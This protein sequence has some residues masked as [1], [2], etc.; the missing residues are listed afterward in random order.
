MAVH[1]DP[2]RSVAV[3]VTPAALV[4]EPRALA[5][6]DHE[7]VVALP[8]RLLGEGVPEP[9][10]IE[11]ATDERTRVTGRFCQFATP[12]WRISPCVQAFAEQRRA[13]TCRALSRFRASTTHHPRGYHCEEDRPSA[14]RERA[15]RQ[16]DG[17]DRRS[18]A[19]RGSA[20]V[21]ARH[22]DRRPHPAGGR[23]P[24]RHA[25]AP[26]S[27]IRRAWRSSSPRRSPRSSGSSKVVVQ[28][29]VFPNLRAGPQALRPLLRRGDDHAGALQERRLLHP[30]HQCRSGRDDPQ[31]PDPGA[32]VA[33]R[34]Q[35]ADALRAG[36]HDGR[37]VHQGPHQAR[38]GALP[39]HDSDHVPA[40]QSKQCDVSVY[41]VPILGA[42]SGHPTRYGDIVGRIVTHEQYGIVFQKGSKLRAVVNPVAQG[43]D[44]GRHRWQAAEEVAVRQLRGAACLQV[45]VASPRVFK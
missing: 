24:G 14:D 38:Q 9:D 27:S 43:P 7:R 40:G 2:Q 33:R 29:V 42:E 36:R 37:R 39:E 8:V 35:E 12:N 25:R 4:D 3:E 28:P 19:H 1:V 31:G 15:R 23:L 11:S 21:E 30:V 34:P 26:R 18:E 16:P 45:A 5:G 22:A 44:Q 10:A 20:D 32:E 41:D 13:H 17:G 6:G